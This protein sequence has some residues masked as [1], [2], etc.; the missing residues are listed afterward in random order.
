MDNDAGVAV[1]N[2]FMEDK[3]YI[4][5]VQPSQA[6]VAVFEAIKSAPDAS[7]HSHAARWYCHIKSFG[8][9]RQQ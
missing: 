5:G 2:M 3:S 1:L 4:E 7:K 9:E 6:D 8:A